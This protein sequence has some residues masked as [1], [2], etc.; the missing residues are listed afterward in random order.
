MSEKGKGGKNEKPYGKK[1]TKQEVKLSLKLFINNFEVIKSSI[2]SMK[3]EQF[4]I[5]KLLIINE[6]LA[7][8][9]QTV[10]REISMGVWK[11]ISQKVE[12]TDNEKEIRRQ[13]EIYRENY[14]KKF[15]I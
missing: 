13:K 12:Q 8:K 1:D 9:N 11:L 15:I 14:S 2:A 5:K 10:V 6:L 3:Q 7:M 4:A